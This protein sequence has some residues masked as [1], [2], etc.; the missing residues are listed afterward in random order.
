MKIVVTGGG[1]GGHFY[2]I[3]AVVQA[4]NDIVQQEKLLEPDI[5][6]LAPEPYDQ[7]ALFE[8][9]ITYKHISAGKARRYF[10]VKNFFDIFRT[11]WGVVKAVFKVFSIFP[12]VIFAKGGYVSFPILI[13]GRILGIPIIIHESDSVPGRVNQWAGKFAKK[14]AVSYPEAT[15][16]FPEDKVAYTGNPVRQEIA[17][18]AL[19]GADKYLD[20]EDEVPVILV[21][22]GSQGASAING[23]VLDALLPLIEDYYVIHQAGA[24]HLESVKETS[25]LLLQD[26]PVKKQHLRN[27][28]KPYGFLNPLALR[29]A[30]GAADVVVSRAGSTIFEIAHWGVPSIIIPIEDSHGDHQRK[31]AYSYAR[32]GAAVVMEEQ[33]LSD[34][35]L[36]SQ[37]RE[38]LSDPERYTT[39][40]E[41]AQNFARHDAA[42]LI[43]KEVLRL[44]RGH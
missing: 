32:S 28:Y 34:E 4:I 31:N 2:P 9:G 8:N 33:N 10:S 15:D 41:S 21:L 5:Y 30:A 36:L 27:R 16:H 17:R 43:A 3:I 22:G 42:E 37:I 39:M 20:L 35:I 29:M 25:S 18:P 40:V 14:I 11:G 12:D 19:S 13:A 7:R 1:T 44:A 6:Y 24:Q 26:L 23:I 38:I